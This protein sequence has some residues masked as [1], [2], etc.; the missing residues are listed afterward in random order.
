MNPVPEDILRG[1]LTV[2]RQHHVVHAA[3]FGSLAK[4]QL[5]ESS[6]IDILVEL[7]RGSSLLD[8]VALK[9]NLEEALGKKVDVVTLGALHPQ[10]REKALEEQVVI[11]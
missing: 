11:L 2:L 5:Q 10:I 3:I 8:L 1:M 9:L 6:D 4:G 7:P